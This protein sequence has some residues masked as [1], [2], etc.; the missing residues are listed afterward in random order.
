MPTRGAWRDGVMTHLVE[1]ALPVTEE[2][3]VDDSRALSFLHGPRAQWCSAV[4]CLLYSAAVW[5][6]HP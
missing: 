3:P 2:F 1:V 5:G 4:T 6:R